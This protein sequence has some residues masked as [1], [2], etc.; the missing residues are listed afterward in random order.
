[1][2]RVLMTTRMIQRWTGPPA[3]QQEHGPRPG[4]LLLV[5]GGATSPCMSP[6]RLPGRPCSR[7]GKLP[8]AR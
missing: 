3:Q 8:R 1:M 4:L 5:D 7:G 6:P 2:T